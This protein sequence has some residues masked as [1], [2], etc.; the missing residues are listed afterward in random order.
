M[1]G[2]DIVMNGG[3]YELV[4]ENVGVIGLVDDPA[5]VQTLAESMSA[6]IE[7]VVANAEYIFEA[8]MNND[9]IVGLF[10]GA[11][12]L[13]LEGAMVFDAGALGLGSLLE[14]LGAAGDA[15]LALLV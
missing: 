13:T 3:V 7:T 4:I 11:T 5:V 10:E 15:L 12:E 2:M 1:P 9:M 8:A 14:A 6:G